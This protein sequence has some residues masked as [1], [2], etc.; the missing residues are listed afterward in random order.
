MIYYYKHYCLFNK[1]T[2]K[3]KKNEFLPLIF[4]RF[5]LLSFH[6]GFLIRELPSYGLFLIVVYP[7]VIYYPIINNKR[8]RKEEKEDR[9]KGRESD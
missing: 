5:L 4:G 8:N 9:R 2:I 3:E 7:L 6:E 1:K